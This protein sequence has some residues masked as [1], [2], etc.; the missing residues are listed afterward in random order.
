MPAT[1]TATNATPNLWTDDLSAIVGAL[2]LGV[3]V[4]ADLTGAWFADG[5]FANIPRRVIPETS[6]QPSNPVASE[7]TQML[8]APAP[9]AAI[10]YT[11]ADLEEAL[12]VHEITQMGSGHPSVLLGEAADLIDESGCF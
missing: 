9:Q 7:V 5:R 4:V 8:T 10:P 12:I 2:D 11:L 6:E 3:A 1:P